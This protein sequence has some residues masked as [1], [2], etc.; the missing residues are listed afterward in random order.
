MTFLKVLEMLVF[1]RHKYFFQVH[2]R[3]LFFF[4]FFSFPLIIEKIWFVFNI[5]FKI[6]K[7]ICLK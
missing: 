2:Q 1:M 6:I 3:Q 7:I 4:F 5:I